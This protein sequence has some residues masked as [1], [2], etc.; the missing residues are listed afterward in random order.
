MGEACGGAV[1]EASA[2][3]PSVPAIGSRAS[4]SGHRRAAPGLLQ[5]LSEAAGADP[6]VARQAGAVL[7]HQTARSRCRP[8]ARLRSTTRRPASTE[9]SPRFSVA[10]RGWPAGGGRSRCSTTCSCPQ[11]FRQGRGD[12]LRQRRA[13][14]GVLPSRKPPISPPSPSTSPRNMPSN[15]RSGGRAPGSSRRRRCSWGGRALPRLAGPGRRCRGF[16]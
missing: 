13:S 11:H 16:R 3:V 15:R 2:G 5:Q 8:P 7:D 1:R 14:G 9:S 4:S 6:G 10:R 12:C